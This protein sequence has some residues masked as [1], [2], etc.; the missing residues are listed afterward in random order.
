[1]ET[2]L[3]NDPW[4]RHFLSPEHPEGW[5]FLSLLNYNKL[6]ENREKLLRCLSERIYAISLEKDTIIPSYEVVN[7]LKGRSRNIP[8]CVDIDDFP[9]DY[10]HED[11]FP[12]KEMINNEV[13]KAFSETF[14]KLAG[15]L[16]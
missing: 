2:H 3:K 15:F 4:L 6:S 16:A 14:S 10:R 9:Y 13:D 12:L 7:T 5:N 1:M 8:I 11:P